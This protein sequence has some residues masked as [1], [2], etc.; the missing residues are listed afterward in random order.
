MWSSTV[1]NTP[2]CTRLIQKVSSHPELG[3]FTSE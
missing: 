2:F 3:G 1:L